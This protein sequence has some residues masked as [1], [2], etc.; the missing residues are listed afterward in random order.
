MRHESRC[1]LHMARQNE[2]VCTKWK[3]IDV[4]KDDVWV[5]WKIM[6]RFDRKVR[7]V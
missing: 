3:Q 5:M 6:G 2:A 4:L 1:P 7:T